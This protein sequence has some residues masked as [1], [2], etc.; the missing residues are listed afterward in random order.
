MSDSNKPDWLK[1]WPIKV[2]SRGALL[3]FTLLLA[4]VAVVG[5]VYVGQG[6][7]NLYQG[8]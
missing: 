5:M 1:R 6:Q 4:M 7:L 3:V 8:F 2:R